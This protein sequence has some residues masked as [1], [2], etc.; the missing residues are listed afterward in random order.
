MKLLTGAIVVVGLLLAGS[1]L[2]AGAAGARG[3]GSGWHSGSPRGGSG[4]HS[5]G[6][7]W[8]V[9][10]R[11]GPGWHPGRPWQGNSFPRGGGG[12]RGGPGVISGGALAWWGWPGWWDVPAPTYAAPPVV[13]LHAPPVPI[14]QAPID[15][16]K[17]APA[18]PQADWHSCQ[19]AGVYYPNGTECPGGWLRVGPNPG[20]PGP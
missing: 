10:T 15:L 8:R 16:I 9:G 6:G 20:P 2:P 13:I 19:Q 11:G 3:G 17:P 14:T 12:W 7:G 4:F 18:P 5:A 1:T